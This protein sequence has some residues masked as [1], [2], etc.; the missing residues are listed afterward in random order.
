MNA[1]VSGFASGFLSGMLYNEN[2]YNFNLAFSDSL[3]SATGYYKIKNAKLDSF[4]YSIP[5]NNNMSFSAQFSVEITD[6]NGFLIDR[7]VK[8]AYGPWSGIDLIWQALEVNWKMV[9]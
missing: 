7:S 3:N 5:L 9:E 2:K 6:S 8:Y 1:L 4:N